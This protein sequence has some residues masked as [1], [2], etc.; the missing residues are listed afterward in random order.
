MRCF[1]GTGDSHIDNLPDVA[2][3]NGFF[4][5][6]KNIEVILEGKVTLRTDRYIDPGIVLT[7]RVTDM[8]SLAVLLKNQGAY[9]ESICISPIFIPLPHRSVLFCGR[10]IV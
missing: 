3:V 4:D 5:E 9:T 1:I 7:V 2:S 6:K 8:H 10:I